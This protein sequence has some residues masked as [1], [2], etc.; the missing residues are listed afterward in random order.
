MAMDGFD[1]AGVVKDGGLGLVVHV[2]GLVGTWYSSGLARGVLSTRKGT[3]GAG[4]VFA[5]QTFGSV[6]TTVGIVCS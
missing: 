3:V 2:E 5:L 1:F 4:V 6:M